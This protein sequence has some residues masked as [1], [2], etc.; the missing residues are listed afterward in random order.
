M[1]NDEWLANF[2]L[3]QQKQKPVKEIPQNIYYEHSRKSLKESFD[4]ADQKIKELE[5]VANLW[6]SKLNTLF[7]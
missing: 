3:E 4:N 1:T 6:K 5:D 2:K 7:Y